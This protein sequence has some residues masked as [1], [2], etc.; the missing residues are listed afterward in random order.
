MTRDRRKP[1]VNF[2]TLPFEYSMKNIPIPKLV[3]G[4]CPEYEKKLVGQ[5]EKLARNMRWKLLFFLAY[6]FF[7]SKNV[8]FFSFQSAF[9]AFAY[10]FFS[11]FQLFFSAFF[12]D[13]YK[14]SSIFFLPRSIC[15][16]QFFFPVFSQ[17][18][19]HR[20][21][22]RLG[23]DFCFTFARVGMPKLVLNPEKW[24]RMLLHFLIDF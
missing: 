17:F 13:V 21:S 20:F 1:N 12:S 11:V 7:S 14:V 22:M 16:S 18:F 23:T 9:S 19:S 5:L 2:T 24:T 15:F 3:Q 8:V 6:Q 4:R 10:V